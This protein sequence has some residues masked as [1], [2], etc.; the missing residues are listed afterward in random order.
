[1]FEKVNLFRLA[2][3]LQWAR[4]LYSKVLIVSACVDWD[5]WERIGRTLNILQVLF[6]SLWTCIFLGIKYFK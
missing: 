2:Y 1:M 4:R 6:F 5:E 3:A